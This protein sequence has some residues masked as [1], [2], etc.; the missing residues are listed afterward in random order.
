MPK[1]PLLTCIVSLI[2]STSIWGQISVASSDTPPFT[3]ENIIE[4][5]FLGNGVEVLNITYE[6]TPD[7]VG[8]FNNTNPFIGLKRG[9]VLSTGSVNDI[10]D[11]ASELAD[12]DTSRDSLVDEQLEELAGI[13]VKDVARYTIEFIPTSD[14]LRFRYVF[15]SEEYP[16]FQCSSSNDAFGFFIQGTNPNGPDYDFDNI[17]L[18]PDPDDQSTFLDLPVTI[19]NVNNGIVPNI[20]NPDRCISDFSQYYNEVGSNS[21]PIF[22]GYLDVFVAE[23]IVVPCEVYTIKIAIGDGREGEIDSAV[24][25]EEK[26]FS[27]GS[28]DI[29]LDNP[30][31]DGGISEGCS[32]GQINLSLLRRTNVDFPI[33]LEVLT[34]P[35]LGDVAIPDVDFVI[36]TDN[37]FIPQGER[38]LTIDLMPCLLYTSPSPRD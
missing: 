23:A 34:D 3:T 31:I 36:E 9:I 30:G 27:T 17:A 22:N 13:S 8:V 4:N 5:V 29:D 28:L 24:F 2:F 18:I 33:E 7:A 6:G 10:N 25:L 19:N 12:G 26:S 1:N 15:A 16:Q 21:F 35:T 38:S 11:V 37:L 14:T 32:S 20:G